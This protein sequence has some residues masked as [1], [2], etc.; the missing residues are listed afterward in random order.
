MGEQNAV[1]DAILEDFH[2]LL[3]IYFIAGPIAIF[4]AWRRT[5]HWSAIRRIDRRALVTCL[6]LTPGF[7]AASHGVAPAPACL[8]LIQGIV[9]KD[10]LPLLGNAFALYCGYAAAYKFAELAERWK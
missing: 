6:I 3:A 10:G 2:I 4:F 8:G 1:L 9:V 7:L 5:G